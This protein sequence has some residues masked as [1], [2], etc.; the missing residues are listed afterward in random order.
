VNQTE[1]G[2]QPKLYT[3]EEVSK[4]LGVG[5]DWVRRKTQSRSVE[6][7][8]LGR[9]VRFTELQLQALIAKFTAKP[10]P[11]SSARTRL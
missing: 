11:A 9:N 3:C 5:T 2:M 7:V 10:I 1:V 6:H 8:R 4:M